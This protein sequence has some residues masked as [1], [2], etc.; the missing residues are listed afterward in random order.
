MSSFGWTTTTVLG[1]TCVPFAV[2]GSTSCG[3]KP[4]RPRM[5]RAPSPRTRWKR[6]GITAGRTSTTAGMR[7]RASSAPSVPAM[8]PRPGT[9]PSERSQMRPSYQHCKSFPKAP[10]HWGSCME[11]APPLWRPFVRSC[12]AAR[13]GWTALGVWSSPPERPSR[14][15]WRRRAS[16]ASLPRC[17]PRR[18]GRGRRRGTTRGCSTRAGSCSRSRATGRMSVSTLAW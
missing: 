3:I 13:P 2:G 8:P 6:S 16:W 12:P 14:S 5:A 15:T 4:S 18:R 10:Q 11:G 1:T 17:S 9:S 7:P